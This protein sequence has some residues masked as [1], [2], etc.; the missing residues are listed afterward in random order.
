MRHFQLFQPVDLSA[1]GEQRGNLRRIL[2][3]F[4]EG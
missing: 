4:K 1:G 2:Q 3:A